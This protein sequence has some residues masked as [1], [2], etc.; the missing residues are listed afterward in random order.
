VNVKKTIESLNCFTELCGIAMRHDPQL[1]VSVQA[2]FERRQAP[3]KRTL[4]A[5][6]AKK[7]PKNL[8]VAAASVQACAV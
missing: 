7:G 4:T 2:A 6:A 1:M 5:V 3:R 8:L